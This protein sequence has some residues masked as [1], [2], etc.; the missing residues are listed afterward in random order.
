MGQ[1]GKGGKH[2]VASSTIGGGGGVTY[3]SPFWEG[4][5]RK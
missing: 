3:L 5:A 2:A 1:Q 4:K